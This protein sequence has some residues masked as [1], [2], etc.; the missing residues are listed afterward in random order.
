MELN[1]EYFNT[2]KKRIEDREKELEES[3]NKLW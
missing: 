1:D 2:A 3:K